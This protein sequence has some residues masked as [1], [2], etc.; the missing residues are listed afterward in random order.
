MAGHAEGY[1]AAIA[2]IARAEGVLDVVSDELHR[3]SHLLNRDEALRDGLGDSSLPPDRRQAA[4]EEILGGRAH[5]V[6]VQVV[7]LLVG[8]GRIREMAAVTD[9][10]LNRVAEERQRV[11]AE[12]RAAVPLD[13]D[14]RRRL[15][16]ALSAS[17]GRQVE[18]RVVVDPSIMGG[19]VARVGDMVIDGSVR[20]RLDRLREAM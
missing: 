4:V 6:T 14:Q 16:D 9:E 10:L 15:A 18:L 17:L 7:S 8:T 20:H 11:V 2:E 12:V 13:D 19:I 1:A 3:F 5:R